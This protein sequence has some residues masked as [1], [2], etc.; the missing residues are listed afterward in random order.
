MDMGGIKKYLMV[1]A[2]LGPCFLKASVNEDLVNEDLFS[3]YSNIT[4][5][6][7]KESTR[8]GKVFFFEVKEKV[9]ELQKSEIPQECSDKIQ[10]LYK[11][12]L[13]S[14]R[15]FEEGTRKFFKQNNFD[16][17][18][19][20]DLYKEAPYDVRRRG[21]LLS[22]ILNLITDEYGLLNFKKNAKNLL[23]ALDNLTDQTKLTDSDIV[24]SFSD[25]TFSLLETTKSKLNVIIH[26][27][28][29]MDHEVRN[30]ISITQT[31]INTSVQFTQPTDDLLGIKLSQY[32]DDFQWNI[33]QLQLAR[34]SLIQMLTE[35]HPLKDIRTPI[36]GA[37]FLRCNARKMTSIMDKLRKILP[38]INVI[39]VRDRIHTRLSDTMSSEF[40]NRIES[41]LN[42]LRQ[43]FQL[44][45]IPVKEAYNGAPNTFLSQCP[46][47]KQQLSEIFDEKFANQ[48]DA[49]WEKL[50]S[51]T[52]ENY[53]SDKLA[54]LINV[55]ETKKA[56][57][58]DIEKKISSLPQKATAL[59][60]ST[61]KRGFSYEE[62]C[63]NLLRL[64]IKAQVMCID[65]VY[66]LTK[67]ESKYRCESLL[68][69]REL[70]HFTQSIQWN[71]KK[72]TNRFTP[73]DSD[74]TQE[75]P[76]DILTTSKE[77]E[78]IAGQL[79]KWEE[80]FYQK[81]FRKG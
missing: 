42:K 75:P 44:F 78:E 9:S 13:D 46:N 5:E 34:D 35:M 29:S 3:F 62:I 68:S 54:N 48:I 25:D 21:D 12:L 27:I 70:Q 30:L 53:I 39:Y 8:M 74:F 69:L 24:C 41:E 79:I 73:P 23:N 28:D 63:E 80:D 10:S 26:W 60:R 56:I 71:C 15:K 16:R 33:S 31:P 64:S 57:F 43:W 22:T 1:S 59:Q 58:S 65:L 47:L 66:F 11:E 40:I 81:F 6:Y 67:P 14:F 2:L 7:M 45:T 20:C 36:I 19:L 37:K 17:I 50:L 4:K 38:Q 61:N 49:S 51:L 76:N 72:L 77:I 52:Q 32:L 18:K 55:L